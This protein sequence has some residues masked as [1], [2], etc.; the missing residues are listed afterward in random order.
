MR[1]FQR[2]RKLRT[3]LETW[4]VLILLLALV[5]FFAFGILNFVGKMG[6]TAKSKKIAEDAFIELEERKAGLE[7]D[8]ETLETPLGKERVFR[9]DFGLAKEGEGVIV[10]I[11]EIKEE[12]EEEEK[13]G[14][15]R[16]FQNIFK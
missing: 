9:E 16:F 13:K 15:W 11:D 7:E 5:V 12:V 14:F 1:H 8:I 6:E 4:P 10:V 2:K 3:F